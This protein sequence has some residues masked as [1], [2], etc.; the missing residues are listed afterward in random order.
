MEKKGRR[1]WEAGLWIRIR[2]DPDPHKMNA[3]P[4]LWWEGVAMLWTQSRLLYL[5]PEQE[6]TKTLKMSY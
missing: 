6:K 4:Q 2:M 3:D 1:G 5:E